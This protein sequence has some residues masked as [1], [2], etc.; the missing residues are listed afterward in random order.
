M[1]PLPEICLC[2]ACSLPTTPRL[3]LFLVLLLRLSLAQ[4]HCLDLCSRL[5]VSLV[6]LHRG[7][8]HPE[9]VDSKE[10]QML[11]LVVYLA[12]DSHHLIAEGCFRQERIVDLEFKNEAITHL[13]IGSC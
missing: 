5:P 1:A 4:V 9:W 11:D 10:A 13:R 6:D 8:S 12:V 3:D 2:R 7:L